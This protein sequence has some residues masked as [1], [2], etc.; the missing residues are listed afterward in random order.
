M[1]T[2]FSK[3]NSS[4]E[5][6]GRSS[7]VEKETKQKMGGSLNQTKW[8]KRINESSVLKKMARSVDVVISRPVEPGGE[9]KQR[10]FV[11]FHQLHR[12]FTDTRHYNL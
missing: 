2:L 10:F 8:R 9:L 12:I 1:S 11:A 6:L 7:L 5:Y 4:F 3:K